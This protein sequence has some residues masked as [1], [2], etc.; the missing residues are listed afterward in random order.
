MKAIQSYHR[1]TNAL[2]RAR[3]LPLLLLRLI[4]AFGFYEPAKMKWS[5]MNSIIQWFSSAGFPVPVVSAYLVAVS[6]AAGV[7]L[8]ALGLFTR[9][10]T[11]PLMIIMLVAIFVVHWASG[12]AASGNGFEIPLYYLLMLFTLF[13]MGPGRISLDHWLRNKYGN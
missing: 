13:I 6:E 9:F 12:F 10:I 8:L 5:D 2:E 1:T 7:V 4:L 3:D 11:V